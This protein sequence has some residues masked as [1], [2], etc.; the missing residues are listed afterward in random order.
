MTSLMGN[1]DHAKLIFCVLQGACE[2]EVETETKPKIGLM[3]RATTGTN[4]MI[5][6]LVV[7][8]LCMASSETFLP[9]LNQLF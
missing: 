9:L 7:E 6:A 3:S 8:S 1:E 2:C 4:F 5:I